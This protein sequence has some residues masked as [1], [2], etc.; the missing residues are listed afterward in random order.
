LQ[1]FIKS[2]IE[3]SPVSAGA[4]GSVISSG[5]QHQRPSGP[6]IP[7]GLGSS[8]EGDSHSGPTRPGFLKAGFGDNNNDEESSAQQQQGESRANNNK[9]GHT[10][11]EKDNNS[12]SV[13]NNN[14]IR[15]GTFRSLMHD[16][17]SFAF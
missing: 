2:L 1:N 3:K 9:H 13:E 5:Q 7:Y 16:K 14:E 10:G 17:V 15:M 11:P 6:Q 8:P 12:G 4:R